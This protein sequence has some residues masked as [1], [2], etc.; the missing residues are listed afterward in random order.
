M[1]LVWTWKRD[2]LLGFFGF[3]YVCFHQMF[4]LWKYVK[5]LYFFA[6]TVRVADGYGYGSSGEGSN[7]G[8][9]Y[10]RMVV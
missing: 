9:F 2:F 3:P 7:Y 5:I 6:E 8:F 10:L 4:G 1:G